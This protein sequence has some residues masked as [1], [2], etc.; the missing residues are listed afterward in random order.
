[1]LATLL[2]QV[3]LPATNYEG[4]LK[5]EIEKTQGPHNITYCS[6]VKQ[7]HFLEENKS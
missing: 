5:V 3:F 1:M 6:Q 4:Q 2:R 7:L